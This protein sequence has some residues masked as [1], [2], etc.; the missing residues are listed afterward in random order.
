MWGAKSTTAVPLDGAAWGS[1]STR[2]PTKGATAA[3]PRFL[4]RAIVVR[5]ESG[6]ESQRHAEE[7]EENEKNDLGFRRATVIAV[8]IS[9][10]NDGQPSDRDERLR[11]IGPDIAQAGKENPG[12]G[13][14]CGL[15]TGKRARARSVGPRARARGRNFAAGSST[16]STGWAK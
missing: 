2:A 5:S 8:F 3:P 14:G 13:L 6:R 10:E 9:V 16:I 12:P 7:R 4:S 15:G 1:S 11:A